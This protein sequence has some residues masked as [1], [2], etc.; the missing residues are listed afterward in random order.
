MEPNLLNK[1]NN[2]RFTDE[3]IN[4][5]KHWIET[6]QFPPQMDNAHKKRF[7]EKYAKFRIIDGDLFYSDDFGNRKVIAPENV[8]N[9]LQQSYADPV[10]GV[11][12]G[13][14]KF[15]HKICSKYIGIKL[16]DIKTFL[17]K[18]EFHQLTHQTRHHINKPILSTFP[19]ER[20]GIDLIDMNRYSGSNRGY[21]YIL[22]C[23]DY[24]SKY[25]WAEPLK[26]KTSA[27][28][29][30]AMNNIIA[31]SKICPK[32]LQK[33]NGGEFQGELNNW[34]DQHDIKW[35][36]TT[37]YSPQANGLIE[38]LNKQLRKLLREMSVRSHSLN[39]VDNLATAVENKNSMV[40]STTKYEPIQLWAPTNK[41]ATSQQLQ[42]PNYLP[43][44]IDPNVKPGHVLKAQYEV[45]NKI[46]ALAKAQLEHIQR[47]FQIGDKV[48]I[49]LSTVQSHLRQ[50]VKTGE[51]KYIVVSFSPD[52]YTVKSILKPD[53]VGCENKRYTLMDHTGQPL[54]TQL[55]HNNP[56]AVRKAKRFFGSD[57]ILADN[58]SQT[59]SMKIANKLNRQPH[60][61]II[62]PNVQP[63]PIHVDYGFDPEPME[64]FEPDI[65]NQTRIRRA[66]YQNPI[67]IEPRRSGRIRKAPNRLDL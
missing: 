54:L 50:M 48:R 58:S 25:C 11:G 5:V 13:I 57:M 47:D 37:S 7:A 44:S 27:D 34:M 21:R 45:Q 19:N 38:N 46:K 62:V 12:V 67:E 35:I 53:H 1:L 61:E 9:I 28:V 65:P 18:Q 20:W 32:L 43:A 3:S 30:D 60:E 51:K 16:S 8:K 56:N 36:N 31:K 22:T 23:I 63:D 59:V 14:D 42:R 55:K 15:Y 26:M 33:D 2:L 39:W 64:E 29:V 40:N 4:Q 52:I 17:P 6:K 49:K 66:V 10:M 24:F 41:L